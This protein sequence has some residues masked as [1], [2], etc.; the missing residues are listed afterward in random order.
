MKPENIEAAILLQNN[1]PLDDFCGLSPNEIHHLLY[2]TFGEKSP[3]RIQSTIDDAALDRIPFFRLTEEFLKIIQRD[4]SVKLTAT[5][6]LPRKLIQELYDHRFIT[7][8]MVESG[9][10]KLNREIDFTPLVS[11]HANTLI[12]GLIKARKGKL[13]LTKAGEELL[14]TNKRRALFQKVLLAFTLEF[15]WASNDGYPDTPIVQSGWGYTMYLLSKFGDKEQTV[16]FYADKYLQA[17]PKTLQLFPAV[18][19]STPY[20]MFTS[21]FRVRVFERFFEWFGFVQIQHSKDFRQTE[22]DTVVRTDV[23]VRVIHFD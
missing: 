18:T 10:T 23:L 15:N 14:A 21:C 19:Y 22:T 6:A 20:R 3:L 1:R 5:G 7:D 13:T 17:F 8:D 12:A 4:T 9:V 11:V 2:D 16:Q